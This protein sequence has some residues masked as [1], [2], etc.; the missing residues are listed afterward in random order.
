MRLQSWLSLYR[1]LRP[2]SS[3]PHVHVDDVAHEQ[4]LRKSD[5]GAKCLAYNTS[6]FNTVQCADS[7]SY[8]RSDDGDADA[9][10]LALA[11]LTSNHQLA[12]A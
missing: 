9:R 1:W 2:S 3:G 5:G 7:A 11:Y 6:Q 10:T 8:A 4:S 12:Q